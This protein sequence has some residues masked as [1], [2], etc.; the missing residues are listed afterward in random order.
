LLLSPQHLPCEGKSGLSK[1]IEETKH[2]LLDLV[3]QREGDY[4]MVN[5]PKELQRLLQRYNIRILTTACNITTAAMA[6][7]TITA[8]AMILSYEF[9]FGRKKEQ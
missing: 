5:D 2:E 6:A 4:S 8:G 3:R 1:Q 7:G 9:V